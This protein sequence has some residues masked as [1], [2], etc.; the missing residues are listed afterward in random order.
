MTF[1]TI[2]FYT[3]PYTYKAKVKSPM[4]LPCGEKADIP[5]KCFGVTRDKF[6][7]TGGTE[8]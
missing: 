5:N 2:S 4:K 7:P 3:I 6:S 8:G 1:Y